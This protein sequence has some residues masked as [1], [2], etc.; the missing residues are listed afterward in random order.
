MVRGVDEVRLRRPRDLPIVRDLEK[1]KYRVSMS[2]WNMDSGRKVSKNTIWRSSSSHE[3]EV[4]RRVQQDQNKER[5]SVT[6]S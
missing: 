2:V 4:Q 3:G 6:T 1:T 5:P